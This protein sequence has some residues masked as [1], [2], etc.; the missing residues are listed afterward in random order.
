M[1]V[2]GQSKKYVCNIKTRWYIILQANKSLSLKY[3]LNCVFVCLKETCI[4]MA[5]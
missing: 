4:L 2:R 5:G 3:Y 1:E